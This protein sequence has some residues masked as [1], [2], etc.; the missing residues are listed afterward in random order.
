MK[1]TIPATML[2]VCL[3][4]TLMFGQ[5]NLQLVSHF[6]FEN[7]EI[8]DLWGYAAP[9]GR[10][11]ALVCGYEGVHIVDISIPEVPV[12]TISAGSNELIRWMDV[13]TWNN[14]AY[15]LSSS[16]YG[17]MTIDLSGLPDSVDFGFWKNQNGSGNE[18]LWAH[19][20]WIDENGFG[21]L[22]Y[23]SLSNDVAIL[24]FNLDPWS[25]VFI[26]GAGTG[27]AHDVY[28][29][30]NIMYAV[31]GSWL[32]GNV[33]DVSNKNAPVFLGSFEIPGGYA[34]SVWATDDGTTL[35]AADEKP[36][37]PVSSFDISDIDDIKLLDAFA[38]PRREGI[39]SIPHNIYEINGFLVVSHYVDGI[40]ILDANKPDNL[41]LVG[42][43]DTSENCEGYNGAFGVYPFLPSGLIIVSDNENGLYLLRPTYERACYLEGDVTDETTGLPIFGASIK[44][45]SDDINEGSSDLL[46]QFK[47]G[48][49]S[50]GTFQVE[51][52]KEGYFDEIISVNLSRAA[53][54]EMHFQLWPLS[55]PTKVKVIDKA[56][57]TPMKDA[58]VMVEQ[59]DSNYYFTTNEEGVVD[60]SI[61]FQ[62]DFTVHAGKWGWRSDFSRPGEFIGGNEMI[63]ELEK[64]FEDNFIFDFGWQVYGDVKSGEW[65]RGEPNDI[66][67]TLCYPTSPSSDDKSD[68]GNFCFATGIDAIIYETDFG[69]FAFRNEVRDGN[70]WFASPEIPVLKNYVRP[71]LSYSTWFVNGDKWNYYF[72]EDSVYVYDIIPAD[73]SLNIYIDN[74]KEKVLVETITETHWWQ[75]SKKIDLRSLIEI[76]DQM[77]LIVQTSD[78]QESPNFLEAAFDNFKITEGVED[79]DL[80]Y[81]D[82][83]VKWNIFPNPFSGQFQ[84]E[85]KINTAF[86][87]AEL[88]IFDALGIEVEKRILANPVGHITIHP[89]WAVG[90]YFLVFEIDNKTS[91]VAQMVKQN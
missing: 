38:M 39:E 13:K 91:K 84:V 21:Y 36:Y 9:D 52:K 31:H 83:L 89:D 78:S 40:I 76:T 85:Y 74:G 54:T 87:S 30:N 8:T 35:F 73:D 34:H 46:G 58:F 14:F 3:S 67:S 26:G 15:A 18:F 7:I 48:Q 10:E 42:E 71:E 27:G 62:G 64:G 2:M 90:L 59:A 32:T 49:L 43:Y 70:T 88:H 61:Q 1:M 12:H 6:E 63:I 51:V 75:Q 86:N 81:D 50:P 19:N 4:G 33:V 60:L 28:A 20:I 79:G 16:N 72:N 57:K 68:A 11:Y 24:D 5:T 17:M 45:L 80:V 22:A 25:P 47:T 53:V 55:Y 44:I 65:G 41:V 77:R 82:D 66:T 37:S 23:N 29:E 56:T 69:S